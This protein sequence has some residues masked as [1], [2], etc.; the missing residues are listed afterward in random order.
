MPPIRKY[1]RGL[2]PDTVQY[3]GIAKDEQERLVRLEG[4]KKLS[5]LDKYEIDEVDTF[6]ICKK[7]GLLSPIYDFTNRGGCFFCPN[8][9]EKELRHL[10]DHHKDLWDRLLDLQK[11][12]NKATDRFNR[13]LR[14]DEIDA[15]FRMDDAQVSIFEVIEGVQHDE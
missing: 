12:P 14:F 13:D 4:Q 9:K 6:P 1:Q 11:V 8:A 15:M 7:H 10:Y 2:D 3:V 5:L